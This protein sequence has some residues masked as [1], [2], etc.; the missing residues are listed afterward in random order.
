MGHGA[1]AE[2]ALAAVFPSRSRFPY[3]VTVR[4]NVAASSG[5]TSM[6]SICAASLALPDC[7]VP[8]RAPVA[9]SSI[10]LA[11]DTLL[12]DPT[13]TEDHFG[14]MDCKV[15]GTERGMTAAQVDVKGDGVS[16]E[17]LGEAF[18]RASTAR[19]EILGHMDSCVLIGDCEPR[20]PRSSDAPF[21]LVDDDVVVASAASSVKTAR[22]RPGPRPRPRPTTS[23]MA[24][25]HGFG[26]GPR[27]RVVA[28]ATATAPDPESDA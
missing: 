6:A 18:M 20:R 27:P 21:L 17:V 8:L 9:G 10:G 4:T 25:A 5:S 11:G 24:T 15:A 13:G 19:R 28:T 12:T 26:D 3:A 16:L 1:L 23:A 2:R 22:R 14:S 7:G